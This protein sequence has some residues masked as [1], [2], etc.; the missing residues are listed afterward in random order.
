MNDL[1]SL[2]TEL[3]KL[4]DPKRA[5]LLQGYFKTGKGEYG[6]GDI[7]LG[8]TVP[9][10]RETAKKYVDL[11]FKD[12]KSLLASK[13]HEERLIALLI[14]VQK[15]NKGDE[16]DQKEVYEFYLNNTDGINNWDLVDLSSHE[17][18]GRYLLGLTHS[19]NNSSV[20][21]GN[22]SL[23]F[24]DK[25]DLPAASSCLKDSRKTVKNQFCEESRPEKILIEL[26]KSKNIWE[27]R[28]ACISTFEFIRNNRLDDSI[29]LAEMLVKDKHD[30]MH[31]AVGWMLREVGK[32]DL[33]MEIAFLDRHYKKMPRTM[34][35]YAIEK[36]PKK[37]R[38]AYL[39]GK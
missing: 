1:G 9:A 23:V 21:S 20:P 16:K 5:K 27:R 25:S 3:K 29:R 33:K 36:F 6:E 19:L 2:R 15:F 26:A 39:R 8:L 14:L 34:L 12:I 32:K 38:L 17:I 4:A 22:T 11:S 18:V 7:F 28:I 13:F 37:L 30:L 24:N 10:A 35:R 31:K